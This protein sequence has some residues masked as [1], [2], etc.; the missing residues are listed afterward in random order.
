MCKQCEIHAVYELTNKRKF[1]KRCFCNFFEKKVLNTI[2]K[3]KMISVDDK[4]AV[5]CSGGKDST[6]ALHILNRLARKRKQKIIAL[7]VDEGMQYRKNLLKSLKQ[8]CRKNKIELKIISFKKE[9][10]FEL[11]AILEKISKLK[12]TNCYVCSIIKRWLL[13]KKARQL[14]VTK[15]ATGHSL[16]DEAETVILNIMKGNPLLLAKLGAVSGIKQQEKFVQRVKP[17][18]FCSSREVILYAKLQKLPLSLKACPLR[19]DTFRIRIRNFLNEMEKQHPEIKN[20]IVNSLLQILP[21]LKEKYKN[22]EICICKKCKEPASKEI[23]KCCQL[24]EML[25]NRKI[26]SRD[27]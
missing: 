25:K 20:A 1:C 2:R 13:N 21:M 3:Y 24:L 11:Q 14:G 6:A 12:L 7:A 4:I 23:C 26:K 15:I 19:K 5:A 22:A 9:Y 10:G 16:D 17:L 8:Y 27:Q 18:Y